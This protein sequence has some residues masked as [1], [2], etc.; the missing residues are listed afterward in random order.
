[1]LPMNVHVE[2]NGYIFALTKYR[3]RKFFIENRKIMR[4]TIKNEKKKVTPT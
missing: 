3:I 1:M 2:L 4:K